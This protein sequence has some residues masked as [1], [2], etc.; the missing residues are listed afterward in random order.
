MK[1]RNWKSDR[2]IEE[3]EDP[4]ESM[5]NLVDIML[6]FICGLVA[7]LAASSENFIQQYNTKEILQ[8]EKELPQIP[9][10][11]GNQ[12]GNGYQKVGQVYKDPETGKLILVGSE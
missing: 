1:S 9:E 11:I 4:L 10:G 3:S 7:A 2:F 12:G 5:A 6:V 8:E